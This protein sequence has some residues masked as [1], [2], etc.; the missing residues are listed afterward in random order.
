MAP[1]L[2]LTFM[3]GSRDG[4]VV[5]LDARGSPPSISIGRTAPCELVITDDPDLSRRHARIF[6]CGTSWMLEDLNSSNG[7]FIGEFHAARR[8][9]GTSAIKDGE[10]FRA[11]LTRL[12]LGVAGREN[13]ALAR[14]GA[15][16]ER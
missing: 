5:Q 13:D 8:L 14:A 1:T 3:S 15:Y 7:V 4:E 9:A 2:T 11:G 16:T 12:R 6:W 10:I